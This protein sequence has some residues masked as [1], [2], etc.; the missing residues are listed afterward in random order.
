MKLDTPLFDDFSVPGENSYFFKRYFSLTYYHISK[1]SNL[2]YKS[3]RLWRDFELDVRF[4]EYYDTK[5]QNI[6]V[7]IESVFVENE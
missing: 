2:S 7:K 3:L 5:I 1:K 4:V 6:V